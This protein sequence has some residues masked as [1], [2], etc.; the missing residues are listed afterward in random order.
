M[1]ELVLAHNSYIHR[2]K[3]WDH[4]GYLQDEIN[5]FDR[6]YHFCTKRL[7]AGNNFSKITFQNIVAKRQ[8]VCHKQFFV[9]PQY[10]YLLNNMSHN[11]HKS[12]ILNDPTQLM[13]KHNYCGPFTVRCDLIVYMIMLK[14]FYIPLY[15]IM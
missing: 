4:Q 14:L 11:F 3:W 9:L 5:S 7:P 6:V 10:L 15:M 13:Y 12:M 8:I 1:T 2:K